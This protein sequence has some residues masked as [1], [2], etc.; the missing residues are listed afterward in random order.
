MNKI[1]ND[2]SEYDFLTHFLQNAPQIMW[3]L[4]SGASRSAGM[5]TASDI[6]WDLKRKYYCLHENQ[7]IKT[8]DIIEREDN[9]IPLRR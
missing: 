2:F 3:F 4:G 5:P 7:D 8:H 6:T 9:I 1:P